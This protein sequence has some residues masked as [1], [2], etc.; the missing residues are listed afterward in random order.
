MVNRQNLAVLTAGFA[1]AA[2]VEARRAGRVEAEHFARALEL[3]EQ[4]E[5][6]TDLVREDRERPTAVETEHIRSAAAARA[7]REMRVDAS[8][9]RGVALHD[10]IEVVMNREAEARG[11]AIVIKL[12]ALGPT[13]EEGFDV[14]ACRR[15]REDWGARAEIRAEQRRREPR[16]TLGRPFELIGE[17]A[18]GEL[19]CLGRV[20]R[21]DGDAHFDAPSIRLLGERDN[22]SARNKLRNAASSRR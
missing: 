20:R 3:V 7:K 16:A 10:E 12:H 6:M 18:I 11:V 9:G 21:I 15:R 1:H 17:H 8:G 14:G 4:T 2:R 22:A 13:G 19:E 5:E